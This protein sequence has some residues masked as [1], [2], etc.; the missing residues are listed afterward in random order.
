VFC[1]LRATAELDAV[2]VVL[3]IDGVSEQGVDGLADGDDADWVWVD[4]AKHGAQTLDLLGISKAR[5]LSVHW[6]CGPNNLYITPDSY[7]Y[8]ERCTTREREKER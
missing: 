7:H 5:H 4:L 1:Y 2:V 8:Q 6:H 3:S